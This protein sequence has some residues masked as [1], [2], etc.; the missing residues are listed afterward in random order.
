MVR[1]G[2]SPRAEDIQAGLSHR[3]GQ[4]GQ[5]L[6]QHPSLNQL[7]GVWALGQADLGSSPSSASYW[8]CPW[9]CYLA[10]LVQCCL[11]ENS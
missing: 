8:L 9:A 3:P 5:L 11:L 10:S 4:E 6:L 2:L 7:D 1:G